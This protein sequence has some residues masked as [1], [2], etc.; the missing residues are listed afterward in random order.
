MTAVLL[1]AAIVLMVALSGLLA[2]TEAVIARLSRPELEQVAAG[3]RARRSIEAIAADPGAHSNALTFARVLFESMSAVLVTLILTD[4]FDV[5]WQAFLV[6]VAIMILVSFIIAGTSPRSVARAHPQQVMSFAAPIARAVRV[7]IGPV[8]DLLVVL[9]DRV[10]P[11][12]PQ[13]I[14]SVSSEEEL[15]NMVDE[16]ADLKVLE[17]GDRELIHSVFE[18]SDRLVREV[19]V[20]RTDMVTIDGD[21]G[22]RDALEQFLETGISRA[23]VVGRDSDDILGVLYL[24]D[25]VRQSLQ[26]ESRSKPA[27]ELARQADFVPESLRADLLLRRMQASATHLSMVVDEYG[28]IAGLVTLED[29][30]E[31]LVGEISDEYDRPGD[32]P[33]KLLDGGYRVSSRLATGELGDLFD[34]DLEFDDVDS[35]GGLL[36]KSLSKIPERGDRAVVDGIEL[37][38]ERVGPRKRILTV[39]A[40]RLEPLQESGIEA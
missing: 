24:K 39:L 8:A 31:E 30:I 37:V 34:I 20:A 16:A 17:H 22:V 35:V 7:V 3:S 4:L 12:R 28:G 15:L 2:A 32:E 36:A 5:R 11:G 25:L 1:V 27:V 21:E 18:F 33:R 9:G 6:S 40:R 10:T 26:E 14:G 23:P 38:A 19:M 29:L 13:R